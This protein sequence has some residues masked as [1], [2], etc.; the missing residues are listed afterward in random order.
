MSGICPE[1][2]ARLLAELDRYYFSTDGSGLNLDRR[3]KALRD[4]CSASAVE[5]RRNRLL[6]SRICNRGYPKSNTRPHEARAYQACV[7]N[8]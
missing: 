7:E 1:L 5:Y 4:K 6:R 8:G 2:D 3:G